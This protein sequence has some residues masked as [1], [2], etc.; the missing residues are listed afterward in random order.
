MLS[1]HQL[2]KFLCSHSFILLL[3]Q[4][5]VAVYPTVS[6]FHRKIDI[7]VVGSFK[8]IKYSLG[9]FEEKVLRTTAVQAGNSYGLLFYTNAK[10]QID[11]RWTG[12]QT[13][14]GKNLP[15]FYT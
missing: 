9:S 14:E 3:Q 10:L 8:Q 7:F 1:V 4:L 15:S 11:Q 6:Y 12:F 5:I 2:Q 13:L